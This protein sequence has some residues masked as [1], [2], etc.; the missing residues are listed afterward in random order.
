MEVF[1][2][3][4]FGAAKEIV[5]LTSEGWKFPAMPLLAQHLDM[6]APLRHQGY[7]PWPVRETL[8]KALASLTDAEVIYEKQLRTAPN[9][10]SRNDPGPPPHEREGGGPTSPGA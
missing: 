9:D 5:T 2:K 3:I 1:G 4:R 10:P 7:L 6:A 8:E